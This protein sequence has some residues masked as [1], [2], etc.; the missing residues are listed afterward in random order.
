MN[1]PFYGR[2]LWE[3]ITAPFLL[4]D[5][6]GNQCALITDAHSP[7]AMEIEGREIDWRACPRVAEVRP[8][9]ALND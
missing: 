5:T 8:T 7:C 6:R 9:E 2:A 3:S 4:V 1:C